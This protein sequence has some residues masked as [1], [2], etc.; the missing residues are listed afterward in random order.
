[1]SEFIYSDQ[2]ERDRKEHKE[3]KE[4]EEYYGAVEVIGKQEER[5]GGGGGNIWKLDRRWG[6]DMITLQ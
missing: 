2:T 4:G 6:Q 5:G 3:Y 1:M